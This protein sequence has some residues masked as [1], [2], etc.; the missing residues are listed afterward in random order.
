MCLIKTK[1]VSHE[2]NKM[3][4]EI[5]QRHHEPG[6]LASCGLSFEIV[7]FVD[8]DHIGYLVD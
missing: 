6:S 1:R 8:A 2:G 3:G 5:S 7:G 4:S